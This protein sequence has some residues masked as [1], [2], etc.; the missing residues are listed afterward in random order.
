[1][2]SRFLNFLSLFA[3]FAASFSMLAEPVIEILVDSPACPCTETDSDTD[4]DSDDDS[5][6]DESLLVE[7][8]PVADSFTLECR[9]TQLSDDVTTSR[10]LDGDPRGPPAASTTPIA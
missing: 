5:P 9:V 8:T 4:A 1:M 3:L 2:Q 7:K 10:N 6:D